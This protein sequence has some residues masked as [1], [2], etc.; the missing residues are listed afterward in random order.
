MIRLYFNR[1]GGLPWSVD[2]GSG[3]P[4]QL[5]ARVA[6]GPVYG[7]TIYKPL[8]PDQDKNEIPCAWIEYPDCEL[9]SSGPRNAPVGHIVPKY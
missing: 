8:N 4:E 7:N 9:Q 5:F 1:R 2:E 3:T 6:V